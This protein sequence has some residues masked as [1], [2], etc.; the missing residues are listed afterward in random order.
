MQLNK[1]EAMV[2][3]AE[4]IKVDKKDQLAKIEETCPPAELIRAV[5]DCRGRGT[6][7]VG[8]TDKRIIYYD[9]EHMRG[10]KAVVSIPYSRIT[11]ISSEDKKGLFVKKGF[12]TSDKLAI[13][14]MGMESKEFEFRGSDKAHMAHN[15]IMDYVLES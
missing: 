3:H 7:F 2:L 8:L 1:G 9:K 4:D 15:I 13:S 11:G 6:G 10:S 5:F 14:S 12:F